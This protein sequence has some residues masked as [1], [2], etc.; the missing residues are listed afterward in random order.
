MRHPRPDPVVFLHPVSGKGSNAPR[1]PP[2]KKS[3]RKKIVR[4]AA[5]FALPFLLILVVYL[6]FKPSQAPVEHDPSEV[7]VEQPALSAA[8]IPEPAVIEEIVLP[9]ETLSDIMEDHGLSPAEIDRLVR[10]VKPV[11]NLAKIVA[12]R[13]M[14][15]GIDAGGRLKSIDYP[16]GED[17][18]LLVTRTETGYRAEKKSYAFE[19]RIAYVDGVITDHL[20]GTILARGEA[21]SLVAELDMI[22]DS[23][24]D[25]YAGIQKGDAFRLLVEKKFLDGRFRKYGNI[26]AAEF[27]NDG[28]RVEAFRFAFREGEKDKVDYFHFDG[29][30]LRKELLKSPLRTIKRISSRFTSRRL[31]PIRKVYRAHYGVDYVADNG[32]PVFATADGTVTQ[33]GL[34]GAAGKMITLKHANGYETMYLHLSAILVKKGQR[35]E[36]KQRIGRVGSTGESTGT[37]LDYRIK[38]FGSYLNPRSAKFLPIAPLAASYLPDFQKKAA[39]LQAALDT[40]SKVFLR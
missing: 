20:Y 19:S 2:S 31:H 39:V 21:E 6:V 16:L 9:N 37:H 25:F 28:R 18:F 13:T 36:A 15:V 38:R 8:P 14:K 33:A 3:R 27:W 29:R 32:D 34:N 12:G 22:F 35:V 7:P 1:R 4:T 10:D 11:F 40:P 24:I 30:S 26:L 17:E 23:D 5:L